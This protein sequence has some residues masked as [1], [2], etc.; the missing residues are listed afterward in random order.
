MERCEASDEFQLRW[1]QI[2]C[3][4]QRDQCDTTNDVKL[5]NNPQEVS[6]MRSDLQK[7]TQRIAYLC[8]LHAV[9]Y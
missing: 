6:V 3:Y 4:R 8:H 2:C 5:T 1:T 7:T 9:E